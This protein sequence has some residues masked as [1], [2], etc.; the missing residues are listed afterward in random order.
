MSIKEERETVIRY[1]ESDFDAY[2]ST[3]SDRQAKKWAKAGVK[4]TQRG[5]E[6]LGRVEKKRISVRKPRNNKGNAGEIKDRMAKARASRKG[7]E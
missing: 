1:D 7:K 4:L 2:L 5:D 3:F 6:W